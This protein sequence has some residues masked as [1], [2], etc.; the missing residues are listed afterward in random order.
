M[1]R[2]TLPLSESSLNSAG[3]RKNCYGYHDLQVALAYKVLHLLPAALFR[4]SKELASRLWRY[5]CFKSHVL[6]LDL[7]HHILLQLQVQCSRNARGIVICQ[8]RTQK[9]PV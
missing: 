5:A 9:V 1:D 3:F 7:V 2:C 8:H 4:G 6:I